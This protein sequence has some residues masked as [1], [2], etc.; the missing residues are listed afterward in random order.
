MTLDKQLH[1][2]ITGH[3]GFKGSWLSM[4]L[5][6]LGQKVSGYSLNPK[7]GSLFQITSLREKLYGDYRGDVRDCESIKSALRI[8]SPDVL[9]HMAAQP[10]VREGYKNPRTTFETNVNGTLNILEAASQCETI[11]AQVIVTTDKVYKNRGKAAGYKEDDELGGDDPYSASKAMA[12]IL[13]QSWIVSFPK[14]PTAV[15]R[16]GNVIGGGDISKD[17]LIPDL[18]KSFKLGRTAELRYPNAVRPWQHVLDC[19]NGYISLS[20]YLRN[21]GLDT[22]WNFGPRNNEFF[23]VHSVADS[24]GKL[25][26]INPAWKRMHGDHPHEADLLLL[27]SSKAREHLD[28]DD[29][30]DFD[31][32]LRLTSDWYMS[33]GKGKS[34]DSATISDIKKFIERGK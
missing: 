23:S 11:S 26:G 10:L 3:T 31:V 30:F 32:G 7:P 9:I 1:Y 27:D 8:S 6:E 19:V 34:P 16:G 18:I 33:V 5:I 22:T 25:W 20:E 13:T 15:A 14:I 24:L 12:D 28:W 17:R 4:L 2:F 29:R 21:G